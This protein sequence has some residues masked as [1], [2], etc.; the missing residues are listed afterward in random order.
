MNDLK[1]ALRQLLKNPGFAALAVLTLGLGLG[2]TIAIFSVV[3]SVLLRPLPYPESERLMEVQGPLS[4]P[5]FNDWQ[6]QQSVFE[7]LCLYRVMNFNV[8][9]DHGSP[10]QVGGLEMS[11]STFTAL[12]LNPLLGRFYSGDDDRIG[13]ARV[14]VLGESYWRSRFGGDPGVLGRTLSID[15]IAH[16]VIGVMP[17]AFEL[18]DNAALV[19]PVE[20]T[21]RDT[22]RRD[23]KNQPSYAAFAR[24][25]SG[26]SIEQAKAEMAA[27]SQRL[28]LLYPEANKDS[29]LTL[30]PLIDARVGGVRQTLWTLLGAVLLVL[31]IACANVA[32]LLLVRATGRR[33]EMAVRTA[34]GADPGRIV[35]QL[36]TENL[37][38]AGLGAGLGLML[39]FGS[40]SLLGTLAENNLPRAAAIGIDGRVLGFSLVLALGT[41]VLF[42]LVPA[43]QASR[44][45]LSTALKDAGRGSSSGR[46]PLLHGLTVG[47][48]AL[49]VVLLFGAGL[50]LRSFQRLS[51]VSAGFKHEQVVSFRLDLPDGKFKTS[52][53]IDRF[54]QDLLGRLRALRGVT[55][56]SLATGLP[57]GGRSWVTDLLIEARPEPPQHPLMEAN[58][59]DADYFAVMGIPVLKGRAFNQSDARP[60]ANGSGEE[61]PNW[62][63]MKTIIIDEEFARRQF[64]NEDPVGKQIRLPWGDTR[65][66]QPVMTVV[67]IVGRVK[68][69]KLREDNAKV[70]PMG[71]LAYRERPN[72]H[73][74]VVAKTTLSLD[75]FAHAVREQMAAVDPTIPIYELQTLTQMRD[76]NIAPERL[77]MTLLGTAALIALALA[78]IGI[79]G[80]VAFTVAQRQR[81]IGVRMA[82]GAQRR[83][84]LGLVFGH[85]LKLVV[86]GTGL[87][88]V[89][90]IGFGRVLT[91]LLFQVKATDAPTLLGVPAIL[92]GAALLACAL[93]ARRAAKLDPVEL[94]RT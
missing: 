21:I 91:S 7:R 59:V 3:N 51:H 63:G 1:F 76:A 89:G 71:Y 87:G 12:R 74:A 33:K 35:R 10:A 94:L 68:Q 15:G 86:I 13:A 31:F 6:E 52:A 40:M 62:K 24:L 25:K 57:I 19:I 93:P 17:A 30:K 14:A 64:P 37:L 54:A 55:S 36:L 75:A 61:L 67:G 79:Y 60:G 8:I 45:D 90:A 77:N 70:L 22:D 39:A 27:I 49:S 83:D 46:T 66:T 56:A 32:N 2:A 23:R 4:I 69:E 26:I 85:G 88:L 38:L 78:L 58:I 43:W 34:L 18:M 42:G 81:E 65:D 9:A 28:A 73:V 20:P 48:V 29:S 5:N 44:P 50:L 82:L 92:M 80:V 72:R 84:V 16:T 47:Q 11:A 41:G 53:P